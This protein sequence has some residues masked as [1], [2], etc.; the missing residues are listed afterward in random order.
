VI[1]LDFAEGMLLH[2]RDHQSPQLGWLGADMEALPL[3]AC[4]VDLLFSSLA[5]QWSES[6]ADLFV[7]FFRILRPG[8][9]VALATLGPRTL[10]ELRDSWRLVDGFTHVNSFSDASLLQAAALQAGFE[11]QLWRSGDKI[12]HYQALRDLTYELKALG[13]HNV[14][15]ERAPGLTG[16]EKIIQLR[17][18]YE[19]YRTP[20]GLPATYEVYWLLLQKPVVSSKA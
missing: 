15:R 4:S 1:G 5:V 9:Q 8:G 13:A 11:Q 19:Q 14:N 17:K 2:A 6:L 3:A 12:M 7:E 20:L 10:F 18:S 16:R